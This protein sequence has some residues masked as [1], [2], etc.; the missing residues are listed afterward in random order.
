MSVVIFRL[1]GGRPLITACACRALCSFTSARMSLL[2]VGDEMLDHVVLGLKEVRHVMGRARGVA[3]GVVRVR[4]AEMQPGHSCL[5][6]V[7]AAQ[8]FSL[9]QRLPCRVVERMVGERRL[10]VVEIV[11]AGPTDRPQEFEIDG[12]LP[13]VPP[14]RD[15]VMMPIS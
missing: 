1:F 12:A 5:Q 9:A 14:R 3:V 7:D 10:G 8:D 2:V 6:R 11:R 15:Q 4:E 13:C